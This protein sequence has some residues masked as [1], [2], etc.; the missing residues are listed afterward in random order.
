MR[1][2]PQGPQLPD[3]VLG[4]FRF[5]LAHHPQHG[6]QTDV[7]EAEVVGADAELELAQRLQ[8]GHGLDVAHRAPQ[9]DDTHVAGAC[10]AV[11]RN[12]RHARDPLLD[13]VGDVGD[14]LP[15]GTTERGGSWQ[16]RWGGGTAGWGDGYLNSFP[17]IVASPLSFDDRLG[18]GKHPKKKNQ[19]YEKRQVT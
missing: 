2:E 3:A 11:H 15:G 16:G 18:G 5:L 13:G 4:G 10:Q 6:H 1:S 14:H 12:L 7:D 9:L 19:S 8:E 17:Q